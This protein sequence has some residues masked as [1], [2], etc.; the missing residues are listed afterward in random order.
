MERACLTA[1]IAATVVPVFF[2]GGCS[3]V[4]TWSLEKV[5]ARWD[6][7]LRNGEVGN[8]R[9]SP[10]LAVDA[11]VSR[12]EGLRV[13]E[14]TYGCMPIALY[15]KFMVSRHYLH[16][17]ARA[18]GL[19]YLG[20]VLVAEPPESGGRRILATKAVPYSDVNTEQL[21]VDPSTKPVYLQTLRIGAPVVNVAAGNNG[22]LVVR[23]EASVG[24]ALFEFDLAA[25]LP[26]VEEGGVVNVVGRQYPR[27][28]PAEFTAWIS[29]KTAS[30]GRNC[31]YL[32]SRELAAMDHPQWRDAGSVT[33]LLQ[34]ADARALTYAL[35]MIRRIQFL[36]PL[37]LPSLPTAQ[38]HV[39]R[40]AFHADPAIRSE[41]S[42]LLY[43]NA[44]VWPSDVRVL[45]PLLVSE[46]P[47]V[48]AAVLG[49]YN[50]R[51]CQ[52]RDTERVK[53]LA[54]SSDMIVSSFARDMVG[55]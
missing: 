32:D 21:V 41:F 31:G 23:M 20:L 7:L 49:I 42:E 35:M 39:L 24:P 53:E 4:E 30:F 27:L 19:R 46:D 6:N 48:Q 12:V 1:T 55:Q 38:E 10:V 36:D 22:K 29:A 16:A 34:T 52:P 54:R 5:S 15:T 8:T 45:E 18:A 37:Y 11:S 26:D 47:K 25:L 43:N 14:G 2:F 40:L 44:Q 3:L 50:Q 51:E 33:D 17:S 28:T 9:Y 13:W